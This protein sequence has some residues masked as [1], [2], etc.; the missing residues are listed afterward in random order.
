[1]ETESA[2]LIQLLGA[3]GFGAIIGW[4]VYY[5]NRYRKEDVQFSDLTTV[6]SIIGGGA[7]LALFPTGTDLFGAYGIGLF[8]GF[9]LYFIVLLIM[10]GRTTAFNVDWF[11]DGRR[12]KVKDTEF[13]PGA[14]RETAA[15]MTLGQSTAASESTTDDG[16]SLI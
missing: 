5:I 7:I 2:S 12:G 15:A 9:F 3:G 14:T 4:Y 1:M 6:I 13:I 11:L 10:V 8:A 16:G